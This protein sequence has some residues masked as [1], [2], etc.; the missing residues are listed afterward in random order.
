MK[1]IIATNFPLSVYALVK[2]RDWELWAFEYPHDVLADLKKSDFRRITVNQLPEELN[3][4]D[5]FN[6]IYSSIETIWEV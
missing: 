6:R 4:Y 3:M 2:I 1:Y 5:S